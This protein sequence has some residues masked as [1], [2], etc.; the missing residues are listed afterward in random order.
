MDQVDAVDAFGFTP[1]ALAARAGHEAVVKQLGATA[2][3]AQAAAVAKMLVVAPEE[4]HTHVTHAAFVR[5][6][7]EPPPENDNRLTVLT[8][9]TKC[10]RPASLRAWISTGGC[11]CVCALLCRSPSSMAPRH[12][13]TDGP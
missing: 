9:P 8:H 6:G 5:S 2:E 3:A 4:C 10:V 1:A 11:V 13:N 12:V 7:P